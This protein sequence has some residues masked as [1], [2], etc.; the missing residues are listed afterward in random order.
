MRVTASNA[1]AFLGL[2]SSMTQKD[3]AASGFKVY[4][5]EKRTSWASE[6]RLCWQHSMDA[7]L[8]ARSRRCYKGKVAMAIGTER[9]SDVLLSY[10]QHMDTF[11]YVPAPSLQMTPCFGHY[12]SHRKFLKYV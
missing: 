12:P 4:P 11:M 8:R 2:K 9:E 7:C 5:S 6:S 10:A 1:A 3:M